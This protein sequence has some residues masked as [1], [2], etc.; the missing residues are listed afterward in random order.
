MAKK[1]SNKLTFIHDPSHG[2]LKVPMKDVDALDIRADISSFSFIDGANAYLEEDG[3]CGV[4]FQALERA[5]I[6]VPDITPVYVD[7]FDRGRERF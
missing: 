1:I 6:P 5:G 7:H 3:D 4:Y 2:W